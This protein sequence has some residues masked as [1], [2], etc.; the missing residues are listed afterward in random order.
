MSFDEAEFLNKANEFLKGRIDKRFSN[1]PSDEQVEHHLD[2]TENICKIIDKFTVDFIYELSWLEENHKRHNVLNG[3]GQKRLA[4]LQ[5][6]CE[7]LAEMLSS[8]TDE[9]PNGGDEAAA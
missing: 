3:D 2:Q 4:Y 7:I 9:E 8:G 5:R 1:A 6:R